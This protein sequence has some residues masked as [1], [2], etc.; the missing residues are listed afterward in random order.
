MIYLLCVFNFWWQIILKKS[1]CVETETEMSTQSKTKK[2]NL[3]RVQLRTTDLVLRQIIFECHVIFVALLIFR[4]LFFVDLI[5][6]CRK[7]PKWSR[8]VSYMPLYWVQ[9]QDTLTTFHVDW[10]VVWSEQKRNRDRLK[11]G[12]I[13]VSFRFL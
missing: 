10:A 6:L 4:N 2:S 12:M 9:T 8:H 13:F 7:T 5:L 11:I 1:T 3:Y